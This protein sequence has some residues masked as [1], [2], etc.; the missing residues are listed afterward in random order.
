MSATKRG[1]KDETGVMSPRGMN[2]LEAWDVIG[3]RS[4]TKVSLEAAVTVVIPPGLEAT[5]RAVGDVQ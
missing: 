2:M 3:R 4:K 5:C 1:C